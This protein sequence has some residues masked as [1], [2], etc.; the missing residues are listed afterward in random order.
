MKKLLL[1]FLFFPMISFIDNPSLAPSSIFENSGCG[2]LLNSGGRTNG[3]FFSTKNSS[4]LFFPFPSS[5][6]LTPWQPN[7]KKHNKIDTNLYLYYQEKV[8]DRL[9]IAKK[10]RI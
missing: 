8:I 5:E 3:F 2:K 10:R 9:E 4:E 1:V 6:S 7:T